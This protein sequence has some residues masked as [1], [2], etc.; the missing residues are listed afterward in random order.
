M[1]FSCRHISLSHASLYCASQIL[2][3]YRWKVCGNPVKSMNAI[4]PTACSH[5]VSVSHFGNSHNVSNIFI[6]VS[7]MVICDQLSLMLLLS[8]F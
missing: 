8:L 5:F 1:F 3:L 2:P 7:A 4:F 6:I